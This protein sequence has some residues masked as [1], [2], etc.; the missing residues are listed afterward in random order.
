[1]STAPRYLDL[2]GVASYLSVSR[3]TVQ[4]L[5]ERK[6]LP[7]PVYL[8][9]KL[10]RWD[11]REIDEAIAR[12]VPKRAPSRVDFDQITE[13]AVNAIAQGRSLRQIGRR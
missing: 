6:A 11:A 1:M 13:E 5:V 3:T 10:P 4:R 2:N 8:S 12:K 7:D 9:P